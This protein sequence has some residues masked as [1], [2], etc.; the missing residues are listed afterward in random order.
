MFALIL[1]FTSKYWIQTFSILK[2]WLLDSWQIQK[3]CAL[4]E[5]QVFM[6]QLSLNWIKCEQLDESNI[7]P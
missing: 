3:L 7:S 6:D 5:E 4:K 1:N 2:V